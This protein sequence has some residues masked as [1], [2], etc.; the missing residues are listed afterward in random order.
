MAMR[1]FLQQGFR[2]QPF[3]PEAYNQ[4]VLNTLAALMNSNENDKKEEIVSE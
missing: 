2:M 3:S 4:N 1:Q